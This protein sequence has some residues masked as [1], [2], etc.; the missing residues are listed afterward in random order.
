MTPKSHDAKRVLSRLKDFQRRTAEYVFRRLYT[1]SEPTDRFL[2]ADEVGLGKTLVVRGVIA[3]AIEHLLGKVERIDIVYVCSNISIASQNINR[4]NVSDVQE[5]ARPTRLSLLPMH[6]SGIRRNPLNYVSLTPGTSFDLKSSEGK[7]EERALIHFMLKNK[8]GVSPAGFRRLLQCR[9]SDDRWRWWTRYWKPE[10]LDKD[11][12]DAF[13]KNIQEDQEFHERIKVFCEKSKR[14]ILWGDPERLAV[15]SELRLRLAEMSIDMLEPDLIILDEFQRFRN[16]LDSRNLEARLAHKLFQYP[17][18]KTLL[19]SATPYKMLSLDYEREDDHYGD[20]LKTLEFLFDSVP[21]VE[22]L[23]RDIQA[24]RQSL[25]GLVSGGDDKVASDARDVLQLQ[26]RKVMCRTE[27]V[28]MAASRDAMFSEL[29]EE[30]TLEP[31][32]LHGAVLA[33]KIASSIG[34]RDIVEYWKSSPY[35]VNFLRRYEFR[36]KL[37]AQC[38][39]AP[40]ELVSALRAGKDHLLR[41]NDIQSYREISPSNPRMRYLFDLTINRG[42][43]KI[44]WLPPSMP[45]SSPDGPFAG[46]CEATKCLVF[47]AWN[48]VPDAIASLCS[49]EAE[50]IM[51]SRFSGQFSYSALYDE[52]RPLLRYSRTQGR[53]SGM[54]VL[55]LLYPSPALAKLVD[56]LKIAMSYRNNVLI[57]VGVLVDVAAE[58]LKPFLNSLLDG[59]ADSGPEDRRWYWA[60]PALLDGQMFPGMKRWLDEGYDSWVSIATDGPRERGELFEEH[61]R[62]FRQA[63]DRDIHPPLGRPPKDLLQVVSRMALG[64]PGVCALRA[65]KRQ[66]SGLDWDSRDLLHGAVR[67]SEGFRTL[68]NLPESIALLRGSNRDESYWILALRHCLEG[69]IQSLLDEQCHCLVESLGVI[70]ESEADRG[71]KIGD[72]LGSSLSLRT[73]QLQLDEVLVRPRAGKIDLKSHNTRCRFALRFGELKDDQGAAVRADTVRDAFNSPFR[74]FILASTSIGQEGLDFHTWCHSVVHWN[75]PRNPVDLEQREGRIQRYK[76]HAVRKNIA[77]EYGLEALRNGWKQCG[78]PW[79]FMFELA[80]SDRQPGASDLVPYWIYELE[81]GA[82]VERHV[83]ILPYSKEEFHFR[84]LKRMLAVYRLVFGQPR[85]EDLLEYLTDRAGGSNKHRK[86]NTW[87]ISLEP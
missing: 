48:V 46:I 3:L 61:L 20:F 21:D 10:S 22:G 85:Q 35:L 66:S 31:R 83:P 71:R 17:E 33:D 27:R 78:D 12:C 70:D 51:L 72:S 19:L 49:Y 40:K 80:R 34:A 50:R 1:D 59:V 41:R 36:R 2:V 29:H 57:P 16:L 45:Y 37:E 76:G 87:R 23:E 63:M 13:V 53:L 9:V 44:L 30:S 6:I 84:Q 81:G 64:A 38:E 62:L 82:S 65:L 18:V 75:L 7:D 39:D 67:I 26:L 25:Y 56:P 69:N 60:L 28:G 8:L 5:F 24:F 15:V 73:S 42:L 14:R 79:G 68:F 58:F 74:P 43:W 52:L 55:V 47:S 11:I 4:L 86:L 77:K 54:T 32:D